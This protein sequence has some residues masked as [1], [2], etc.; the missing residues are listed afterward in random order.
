MVQDYRFSQG[1]APAIEAENLSRV[2][3]G[4]TLVDGINLQVYWGDVVAVTGPSGSGKS[5]F[6]RLLNRLDEPTAGRVLLNGKDYRQVPPRDLRRQVGLVMQNPYLFPGTV[7]DNI[8][9]GPEQNEEKVSRDAIEK[10]LSQVGLEGYGDRDSS[11]L[12]GGEAQRVS[13]AR[14]LANSPRILLLDEPTSAL[15]E[16]S[17]SEAENLIRTIINH[18]KLTCLIVTHNIDQAIRLANRALLLKNGR[19]VKAG[20]IEEVL[21]AQSTV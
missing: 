16:E 11:N 7:A 21:R 12:S 18:Q 1:T 5:S 17:Q 20:S 10:W 3:D 9:F 4:K 6:L 8:R 19:A 2:V 13:L 15:D 14:T